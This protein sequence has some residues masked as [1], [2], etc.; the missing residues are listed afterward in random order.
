MNVEVLPQYICKLQTPKLY[1][2]VQELYRQAGKLFS[3][4]IWA[5][6]ML[7][8]SR[9]QV[10]RASPALKSQGLRVV[11]SKNF[12]SATFFVFGVT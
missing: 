12:S 11:A 8:Q 6:V 1:K 10:S 9:I 3:S 4:E 5:N 2:N 7:R